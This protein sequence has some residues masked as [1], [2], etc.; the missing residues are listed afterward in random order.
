MSKFCEKCG[1]E[2]PEEA[3]FCKKCGAKTEEIKKEETKTEET[4]TEEIKTEETKTEETKTEEIKVEE[5][6]VEEAKT[7]EKKEKLINLQA[8][9][10]NHI[11][12]IIVA[13][14]ILITIVIIVSIIASGKKTEKGIMD[15]IET[16]NQSSMYNPKIEDI[17]E[18][19]IITEEFVTENTIPEYTVPED[20]ASNMPEDANNEGKAKKMTEDEFIM[21]W[22]QDQYLSQIPL[23]GLGTYETIVQAEKYSTAIIS[24]ISKE[25]VK[26]YCEQTGSEGNLDL[27]GFTE[28]AMRVADSNEQYG[29]QVSNKSGVTA[30]I[31]WSDNVVLFTVG[32]E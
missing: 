22:Y 11:T 27:N 18:D 29:F 14:M 31:F 17:I 4:K 30:Y 21:C 13:A 25:Q 15:S 16:Q 1:T 6:K 7:E 20:G 8:L 5:I 2:L 26:L 19:N 24:N 23:M 28:N 32:I 10:A 3:V 12:A 9:N